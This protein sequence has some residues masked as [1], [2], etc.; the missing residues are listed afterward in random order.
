MID[1]AGGHPGDGSHAAILRWRAPS[2]A[3][4]RIEGRLQRAATAGDGVRARIVSS[5]QG[6]LGVWDATPATVAEVV[7]DGIA[8]AEGEIIDFVI[9]PREGEGSDSFQFAPRIIETASGSLI[10]DSA[11]EFAGPALDAWVAFA[12]ILLL[13]NEFIFVD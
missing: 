10:A 11:K 7:V 8:L 12:Q 5:R 1:R 9:D 13:S 4:V 2:A 6:S 3:N